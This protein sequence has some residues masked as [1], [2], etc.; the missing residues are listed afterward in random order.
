MFFCVLI[1]AGANIVFFLFLLSS[2]KSTFCHLAK[3]KLT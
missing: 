1:P 3:K 2:Q